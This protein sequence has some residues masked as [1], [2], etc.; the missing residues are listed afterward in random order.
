MVLS[1][2]DDSI[3]FKINKFRT[4]IT[5]NVPFSHLVLKRAFKYD[6]PPSFQ[7]LKI[8]LPKLK[9]NI[10]SIHERETQPGALCIIEG[11]PA[12]DIFA[13]IDSFFYTKCQSTDVH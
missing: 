9:M 3:E 8:F 6:K 10:H 4:K 11:H 12:V 1:N 13:T 7:I 2:K 5:N